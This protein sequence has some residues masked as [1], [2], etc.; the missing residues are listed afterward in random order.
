MCIT[1]MYV[2][3]YVC[4]YVCIY[5]CIYASQSRIFMD[6]VLCVMCSQKTQNVSFK[7]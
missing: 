3:M 7:S 6:F 4:V 5:V 1:C 2:D